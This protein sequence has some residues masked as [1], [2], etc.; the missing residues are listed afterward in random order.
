MQPQKPGVVQDDNQGMAPAPGQRERPEVHLALAP[1]RR[2]EPDQ[3]LDRLARPRRPH[4]VQHA[5]VTARI[6]RRADLVEQPLCRE[7]RESLKTR[8]DDPLVGVELVRHRGTQRIPSRTGRQIPVQL[9]R[10]DPIVNR[11]TVHPEP[12]GQL[13]LRDTLIQIVLQ[14]QVKSE[15]FRVATNGKFTIATNKNH[16]KRR[17]KKFYCGKYWTNCQAGGD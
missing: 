12:P 3:R 2:L 8:V 4:V 17:E 7:L 16:L 15:K 1:R 13:R 11:P 9:A 5:L 10:L 14:Q 6:T